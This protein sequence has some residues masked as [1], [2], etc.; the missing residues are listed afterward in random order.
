[1]DKHQINKLIDKLFETSDSI[2]YVAIYHDNELT[3]KQRT[4]LTDTSDSESDKYEELFV[5]PTIL[6]IAGQRGKLDCGGLNF[7][8]IKYGN[9]FQLIREFMDGHISICI[10]KEENPIEL[11]KEINKVIEN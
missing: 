9:F 5:N 1:V 6:K 3:S 8:I 11:E 7:V 4:E 2:R 10:D